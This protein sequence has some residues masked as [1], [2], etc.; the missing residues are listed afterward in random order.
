MTRTMGMTGTMG[1]TGTEGGGQEEGQIEG[2]DLYTSM[3]KKSKEILIFQSFVFSNMKSKS[4]RELIKIIK[5]II[6]KI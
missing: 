4:S 5:I 6:I 3:M 1:V 2:Q